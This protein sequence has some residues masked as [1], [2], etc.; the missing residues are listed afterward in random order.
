MIPVIHKL[1]Y[2]RNEKLRDIR[3]IFSIHNLYFKGMFTKEVLPELFGYDYEAFN[4]GSLEHN[5]GV[6]FLKGG[7]NYSDKVTTVSKSYVEEIKTPEYG[8]G[9]EGLLRYREDYLDGIVNGI[10]YNEYDPELDDKIEYNYNTEHY[11][12]KLLNKKALQ[13]EFNLEV[14]DE[15]PLIG[16]VSRLTHQKGCDL[17][18]NILEDLLKENVQIFILGTGDYIYE[19]GFKSFA[20]RYPNRL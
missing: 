16:I 3:T 8:E 6:S 10:D 14:N 12:N 11:E 4:N 20:Q 17:I 18:L 2:S 15:I 9:L 5:G 19:E 7:I 13:K 1:E